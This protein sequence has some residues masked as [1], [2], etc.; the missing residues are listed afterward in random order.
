LY[1]PPPRQR[2][3]GFWFLV[4]MAPGHYRLQAVVKLR[5][6][7]NKFRFPDRNE[8]HRLTPESTEQVS[9]GGTSQQW[10]VTSLDRRIIMDNP[11]TEQ[12]ILFQ[13]SLPYLVGISVT[14]D[15]ADGISIQS[16]EGQHRI[17]LSG[18]IF[19]F[20]GTRILATAG[21]IVKQL[22]NIS[23]NGNKLKIKLLDAWAKIDA[24]RHPVPLAFSP[25]DCWFLDKAGIDI[26]LIPL[27]KNTADLLAANGI[28][29]IDEHHWKVEPDDDRFDVCATLG[30][31]VDQFTA[32]ADGDAVNLSLTPTL[33]RLDHRFAVPDEVQRSDPAAWYGKVSKA[34]LASM[35]CGVNG[36]SGGPTFGYKREDEDRITLYVIGWQFGVKR[37][38]AD[39]YFRIMPSMVMG[40]TFEELASGTPR[41]I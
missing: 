20:G 14:T 10:K 4:T 12:E 32:K 29:S 6:S 35:P 27:P 26:G 5:K 11:R 22:T 37:Y 15:Y 38:G 25:D 7:S 21:H 36:L 23:K 9:E 31:P 40:R 13:A 41:R 34:T 28:K 16:S 3:G 17:V 19:E 33:V 18:T 24:D 30:L 39:V 1:S 2:G 8:S